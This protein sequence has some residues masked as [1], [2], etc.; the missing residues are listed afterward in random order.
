MPQLCSCWAWLSL[1]GP[2]AGGVPG[3][4]A[5]FWEAK[6]AYGNPAVSWES[7]LQ[8]TVAMCLQGIEVRRLFR[9]E[10]LVIGQFSPF[11]RWALLLLK[12]WRVAKTTSD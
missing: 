3:Q 10:M 8:P 11:Y 4:V 9:R 12:P 1:E 2:L 7:L 6:Q 5:G